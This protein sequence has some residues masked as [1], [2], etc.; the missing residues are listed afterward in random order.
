MAYEVLPIYKSALELAVYM[1]QIVRGFERYHKYTIGVDLRNKSKAILF[2]AGQANLAEDRL[3]ALV[4]LRNRC[5][6]MK[7]LIHLSRELRAFG[8]FKQFEHSSLLAVT[9][10]KQAQA[11]L[12]ATRR[13]RRGVVS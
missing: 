9:T 10:C 3:S 6:E 2:G 13:K 4:E 1:E 12:D 7:M 8:S 5:E 11:W